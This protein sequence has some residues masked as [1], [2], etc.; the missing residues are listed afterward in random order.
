MVS[1]NWKGVNIGFSVLDSARHGDFMD[2][3]ALTLGWSF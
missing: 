1:K 2:S 3:A